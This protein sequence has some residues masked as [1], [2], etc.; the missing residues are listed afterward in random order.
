MCLKVFS[1]GWEFLA[2]C[3]V[4]HL[5]GPAGS[6]RSVPRL[7]AFCPTETAPFWLACECFTPFAGWVMAQC[8]RTQL[9][10]RL[11]PVPGVVPGAYLAERPGVKEQLRQEVRSSL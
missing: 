11:C 10:S 4:P 2:F 6:V 1:P 8:L 9:S 7:I 5:L 3:L